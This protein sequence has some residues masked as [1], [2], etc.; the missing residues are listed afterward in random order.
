MLRELS[1]F[2]R[3]SRYA[4]TTANLRKESWPEMVRR[5]MDMH[6]IKYQQYLQRTPKLKVY[7]D[8]IERHM[9]EK[10]VLGSQRALQFGGE[11]ILEKNAR[12]YN[13]VA[14]YIDRPEA[15]QQ[16]MWLLLCG[17]GVGFSVQKQHV[18]QLP[19]IALRT[20]RP[21]VYHPD[22]SIEGW[23]NAIGVLVSSFFDE[24][25]HQFA[26]FSGH[27]IVFNLQRIR[28]KGSVIR[29]LGPVAPGPT[30][31][32]NALR[33]IEGVFRQA[34]SEHEVKLRPI[35][36]YDICMHIADAVICG[37]VRRSATISMFSKD[38]IEMRNAKTGNWFQENP[39]RARSNNSVM[40]L[41]QETTSEEFDEIMK[42]TRQFGEPGFIWT[43]HLDAVF[44]PCV[45]I[46]LF[47]KDWNGQSG[48]QACNLNELN[49]KLLN[50]PEKFLESCRVAAMLGTLQAGYTN[51]EYL[52]KTTESIV[53]REALLGVSMTGMMDQPKISFDWEL[54]RKGAQ[55]IKDTNK[56]IALLIGINPAARTTCVK[57]AGTTSCLLETASGI[58]P[59]HAKQYIRRVQVNTNEETLAFFSKYKPEAVEPSVWS[60]SGTDSV[61]SF[62]CEAPPDAL[63]KNDLTALAFLDLVRQTQENWVRHG[64]NHDL[65]VQPWLCHN[66]SN[67]ITINPTDKDW[68]EVGDYIYK[69]R[70]FFTGVSLL[71]AQGDVDY[72]QAPFESIIYPDILKNCAMKEDVVLEGMKLFGSIHRA[73]SVLQGF[74]SI[75]EKDTR[76]SQR[77]KWL[78]L[79]REYIKLFFGQE[80]D[81]GIQALKRLE[82]VLKYRR[83]L[84]N[85]AQ[86]PWDMYRPQNHRHN[87]DLV[88]C[89]GDSCELNKI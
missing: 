79:T 50:T 27:P 74:S 77:V 88:A 19:A 37:G 48:W 10:R 8:E 71:S 14:G 21:I 16:L 42:S 26:E 25:N 31:L 13:C 28:P 52:G 53:K 81:Q 22:D 87:G 11:S 64:I 38:D 47:A 83:L 67:T 44:N 66:V 80:F 70:D 39:Q 51:F 62:A 61:I 29:N 75:N 56:E 43:D 76:Y 5:V 49:M 9:L 33:N 17:C 35:H 86:V 41:R 24:G 15:F 55:V 30:P 73:C 68:K 63:T 45:E 6:R 82:G 36:V 4:K 40:L 54:Q 23:A 46:G 20:S 65:N 58:H 1:E 85:S 18:R 69:Y 57:P 2:V 3:V 32:A 89:S 12:I 7:M 84:E 72:E 59:H 34:L 78:A 60:S